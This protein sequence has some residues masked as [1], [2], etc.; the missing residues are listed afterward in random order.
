[1]KNSIQGSSL[2]GQCELLRPAQAFDRRFPPHRMRPVR[3]PF[4]ESQPHRRI[5]VGIFC[6]LHSPRVGAH[7]RSEAVGPSG[8]QGAILAFQHIN[9]TRFFPQITFEIDHVPQLQPI[10][11]DGFRVVF[12]EK[13]LHRVGISESQLLIKAERSTTT[14]AG[15]HQHLRAIA[16]IE[17]EETA[18]QP[19]GATPPL[20]F[21]RNR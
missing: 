20:I 19:A 17:L 21:W 2:F 7:P 1:M 11:K 16:C 12:D 15:A 6:A 13:L 3:A 10:F 14:I 5:G 9:K 18:H 4:A 8:I